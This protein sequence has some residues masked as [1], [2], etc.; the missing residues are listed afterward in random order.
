M[1]GAVKRR[2]ARSWGEESKGTFQ[3]RCLEVK[4]AKGRLLFCHLQT[5]SLF[6][7]L[8]SLSASVF[9]SIKLE[10]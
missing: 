10:S 5:L 1:F 3:Y 2:K 9:M 7:E 8:P 6:S 4:Q